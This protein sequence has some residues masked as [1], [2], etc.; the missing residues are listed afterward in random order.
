[1][2]QVCGAFIADSRRV[3]Y[4]GRVKDGVTEPDRMPRQKVFPGLEKDDARDFD[5]FPY[6]S[7]DILGLPLVPHLFPHLADGKAQGAFPGPTHV[8]V[9]A[10]I[11]DILADDVAAQP[12]PGPL[13]GLIGLDPDDRRAVLPACGSPSG[14]GTNHE[15]NRISISATPPAEWEPDQCAIDGRIAAGSFEP[16]GGRLRRGSHR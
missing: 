13:A 3:L 11:L 4:P 2:T 12:V 5:L 7:I 6:P 1:M 14:V 8:H 9:A 15:Y 10:L 16:Y